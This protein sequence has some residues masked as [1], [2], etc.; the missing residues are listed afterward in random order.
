M[1]EFLGGNFVRDDDDVLTIPSRSIRLCAFDD[2]VQSGST[3]LHRAAY[4]GHADSVEFLLKHMEKDGVELK[5]MV[6]NL[7]RSLSFH[8]P[9]FVV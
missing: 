9:P 7:K 3:A 1:L 6:R 4:Q 2:G 8:P 5:D